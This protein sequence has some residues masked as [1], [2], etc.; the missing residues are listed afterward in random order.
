MGPDPL[1][2]VCKFLCSTHVF[3]CRLTLLCCSQVPG[4]NSLP[5]KMGS[6]W[7]LVE[8]WQ[9]VSAVYAVSLFA[10]LGIATPTITFPINSQVP[11]VARVSLPFTFTFSESTFSGS[12]SLY[13]TLSNEPSWLSLNGSTRTLSG[14]APKSAANTAPIIQI[15]ASDSTGSVNMNTTLV[16]SGDPAPSVVIPLQDQLAALG[17]YNPPSS[18]LYYPSTPFNIT[19]DSRTFSSNAL[20][21]Y[22][23]TLDNTPLPAWITF[24][25]ASL[26]FSGKT[27][28]YY[29]L[30]Q[31]PQTWGLQLIAS[32]ILGFAGTAIE[33]NIVVG[34]HKLEFKDGFLFVNAT[35]GTFLNFT[36]LLGGLYLDGS[37]A[38][39]SDIV[40][41]DAK[42]PDWLNF[43]NST[44]L[45]SGTPPIGATSYNVSVTVVDI[46]GDTASAIVHVYIIDSLFLEPVG[47]VNATIG[48]PFYYNIGSLFSNSSDVAVSL[49]IDPLTP[50]LSFNDQ[51]MK[52][53]GR[54]P[55]NVQP[56]KIRIAI[57]ATLKSSKA[58][59][60]QILTVMVVSALVPITSGVTK[61]SAIATAR[62]TS[63]V[64]TSTAALAGESRSECLSKGEIAA[65]TLLVVLFFV[66]AISLV[67]FCYKGKRH[68]SGKRKGSPEKTEISKPMPTVS[69][70][71]EEI[72]TQNRVTSS[73]AYTT[74]MFSSERHTAALKRH[75]QA[76]SNLVGGVSMDLRDSHSSRTRSRSYSEN[77]LSDFGST[78]RYSQD[79]AYPPIRISPAR[80]SSVRNTRNFSRKTSAPLSVTDRSS[81]DTLGSTVSK[82][83]SKASRL[84]TQQTPDFAYESVNIKQRLSTPGAGQRLGGSGHGLQKVTADYLTLDESLGRREI[85]HGT[86][87][88][89]SELQNHVLYR[90]E[91]SWVTIG[92]ADLK[93]QHRRS[94]M[95]A[96]TESTEVLNSPKKITLRQVPISP[97]QP[98]TA[99]MSTSS[100]SSQLSSKRA[101]GSSPFF[102]GSSRAESRGTSRKSL[103]TRRDKNLYSSSPPGR[104]REELTD[105]LEKSIMA[106]LRGMGP[107]SSD[108]A[109]SLTR[110]SLCITYG[111]PREG[112]QQ[113]R[114]YVSQLG[115]RASLSLRNS[116]QFSDSDSRFISA[117]NSPQSHHYKESRDPEGDL[118]YN[119]A[120]YGHSKQAD[121]SPGSFNRDQ[122]GL[123]ESPELSQAVGARAVIWPNSP[124]AYVDPS[125][126]ERQFSLNRPLEK[127]YMQSRTRPASSYGHAMVGEKSLTTSHFEVG[128]DSNADLSIDGVN[129]AFI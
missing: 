32:D 30:V 92:S 51:T 29:S 57:E 76:M 31:P 49:Q 46:Y 107:S 102:G 63:T 82:T 122:Y 83:T 87:N 120:H 66:A 12:S 7:M 17:T 44:F 34:N 65:I 27:P 70:L 84:S 129:G 48:M 68:G 47:S 42:T 100:R 125:S 9:I 8:D 50:W 85:C 69:Q 128:S 59:S 62:L 55:S 115:R 126:P 121:A 111:S 103:W 105:G 118:A 72:E 96:L 101:V 61:A 117:E 45:L 67:Y 11:P 124:I 26:S 71:D 97:S 113:L 95:S 86:R 108:P 23:V 91:N 58:S 60:S 127:E 79:S 89:N 119:Y 77:A 19:F 98:S 16:V 41:A 43:S 6:G 78:W 21:H 4:S 99:R 56:S 39:T 74:T 38:N 106:A 73:D 28:D 112:T 40:N 1:L 94:V 24:D 13:Y 5:P 15:T 52:L 104:G 110:D 109:A 2:R 33:F 90:E 22:A 35:I 116:L 114:D 53:S 20:N 36:S 123:D 14:V 80:R 88:Q 93:E 18:I 37:I 3:F 10:A 25:G 75:S 54:V 64:S 81:A